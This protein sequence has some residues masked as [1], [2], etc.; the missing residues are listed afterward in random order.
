MPAYT[1]R[2]C[3]D[4][5]GTGKGKPM[6]WPMTS[7]SNTTPIAK[8][9]ELCMGGGQVGIVPW[10]KWPNGTGS[11]TFTPQTPA[12]AKSVNHHFSGRRHYFDF[13]GDL[14]GDVQIGCCNGDDQ[15]SAMVDGQD[16][17]AFVAELVRRRK[18]AAVE[19]A[20][21]E[22]ILFGKAGDA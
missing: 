11:T 6:T 20:S 2:S 9:C 19:N 17:I 12:E 15:R 14:S 7:N 22:E 5:N 1:L 4:C 8:P 16:L 10:P 13:N 3:P 18:V 21:D